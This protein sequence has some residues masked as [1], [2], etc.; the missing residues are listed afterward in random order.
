MDGSAWV[1][2]SP[3]AA[4]DMALPPTLVAFLEARCARYGARPAMRCAL[5]NGMAGTLTF[6]QLAEASDAVALWLREELG[7]P[8]G[9]VVAVQGPNCLAFPV[10]FWGA[11]KAGM[12]PTA[13][14]PLYTPREVSDQLKAAKAR[15]L[16]VL[17]A[18]A[19]KLDMVLE[20]AGPLP[21]VTFGI[22]E[23]F[24]RPTRAFIH[25]MLRRVKRMVPP[26][27]VEHRRFDDILARGQALRVRGGA[28]RVRAYGEAVT[29]D[30]T[31]T[32][33]FTGGT[34][35][36]SKGVVH[37][38][39]SLLASM[40]LINHA[41][42]E[43]WKTE[44]PRT[45]LVLPFY[46]I[47]GV[48]MMLQALELGGEIILI[49]NPRPLTNLKKSIE[50]FHPTFLPGVPTLFANLANQ[51]WFV[52]AAKPHL[53]LCLAGAAPLT[54]ATQQRW[55][56]VM[57]QPIHELYGMT[58]CGLATATPLD[59][60]D[61]TGSIGR[62]LPGLSARIVDAGGNEVPDGEP[63]ELL[64]RGPQVM[65]GYLDQPAETAATLRDGWLHTGDV[66]VRDPG[67]FLRIVDRRK[68]MLLVS[69]FN[70]YPSEIE[71]VIAEHPGVL[72]CAVIG[73]PDDATGE[74][75]KA[76]VVARDPALT[77]DAVREHCKERLTNYKRPR[78]VEIIPELPKT[79]VGKV[80]KR[81][82]RLRAAPVS[83]FHAP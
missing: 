12:V 70:V 83:P 62:L 2:G 51:D 21:V 14:N 32:L 55:R 34:T 73:V 3:G 67:G 65:K 39:R 64:L 26:I 31:V 63:G 33:W 45:L 66:V 22:A 8:H 44:P 68:D 49:P 13:I 56:Q 35:G 47:F 15:V 54:P 74:A 5:P 71:A 59:G 52:P 58:E 1:R 42:A 25:F 57:G 19:G 53:R 24:A 37:T 43:P 27:P 75:P 36:K 60:Q 61:H 81:E 23:F 41:F 50:R 76:F 28:E 18:L 20:Q 7:L 17:D 48:G 69:G 11:L 40:A 78:Q 16:F 82:L 4:G 30:D 72:E 29:G 46:H 80:L 77:V 6:N 38:H 9:A 10:I 79:P